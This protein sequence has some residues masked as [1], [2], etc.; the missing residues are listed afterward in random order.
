MHLT[1][2][3][4][5]WRLG[6]WNIQGLPLS[7]ANPYIEIMHPW[8]AQQRNPAMSPHTK[9]KGPPSHG[10]KAR[11]EESWLG[12]ARAPNGQTQRRM[13][14]L[15][16]LIRYLLLSSLPE[17]SKIDSSHLQGN[18]VVNADGVFPQWSE[19]PV[20]L[21]PLIGSNGAVGKGVLTIASFADMTIPTL[22]QRPATGTIIPGS[23]IL[24]RVEGTLGW[25][26]QRSWGMAAASFLNAVS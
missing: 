4:L 20:A 13:R 1:T 10:S 23:T 7:A 18:L 15:P 14:M 12:D 19:G 16:P 26:V 2:A 9:P 17:T 25:D 5:K 3:S 11:R 6:A 21:R 24:N 22:T 8:L